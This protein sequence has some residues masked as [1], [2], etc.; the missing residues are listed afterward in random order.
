[1]KGHSAKPS[2]ED[3]LRL[4]GVAADVCNKTAQ[5]IMAKMPIK[6]QEEEVTDLAVKLV[7]IVVDRYMRQRQISINPTTKVQAVQDI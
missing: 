7:H 3:K 1:M 4:E 2:Q 6:T 5:E